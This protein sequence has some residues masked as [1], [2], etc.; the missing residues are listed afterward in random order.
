MEIDVEQPTGTASRSFEGNGN[1]SERAVGALY[2]AH[3]VGLIR[4]AV[5]MLGSRPAAEDV[6]QEAFI[7]LYRRWDQLTQTDKALQYVRSSVLNGCRSQLRAQ[8]RERRRPVAALPGSAASA[9]H[10]ILLGEEH[11]Q[12]AAEAVARTV[13][14]GGAPPLHLPA[15]QGHAAGH[16]AGRL[17]GRLL[18]SSGLGR[19]LPPLAAATAVVAVAAISASALSGGSARTGS[20]GHGHRRGASATAERNAAQRAWLAKLDKGAIDQFLTATGP[21]YTTGALFYGEIQALERDSAATCMARYGFNV[22][23]ITAARAARG[24]YD[25]T[26]FP[27]LGQIARAGTLPSG[28]TAAV[29]PEG[30][31]SFMARLNQCL[32]AARAPFG[33]LINAGNKLAAPFLKIEVFGPMPAAV[34]ATLPRLRSCAARYGWPSQPYGAPDSTINSFA[35]FV[36]WVAGHI[37]GAVSRG[38]SSAQAQA[39]DRRWA[40]AFVT[41]AKPTITV[42]YRIWTA[43]QRTFLRTHQAQVRAFMALVNKIMM[44]AERRVGNLAP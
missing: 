15:R 42:Q 32:K 12:V 5:V 13:P 8:A 17:R 26:Q 6:V 30:S 20:E 11:R 43:E 27:D 41:C 44:T 2:E 1:A 9:D 4:L 24:D 31:R 39:L 28:V 37:D 40:H 14:D 34:R 36:D 33:P 10:E 21:Q 29:L 22:A 38:A 3:A 23:R 7:G 19:L 16:A 35:D 18:P 25:L